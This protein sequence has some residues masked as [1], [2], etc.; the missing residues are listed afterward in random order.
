MAPYGRPNAYGRTDDFSLYQLSEFAIK[1]LVK[2]Q[3]VAHLAFIT[4]QQ[5]AVN[6]KAIKQEKIDWGMVTNTILH[7]MT[8]RST[9]LKGL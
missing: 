5:E 9:W 4:L 1:N 2:G 7:D 3:K 6:L 8:S